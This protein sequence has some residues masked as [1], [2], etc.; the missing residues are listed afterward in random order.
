MPLSTFLNGRDPD[1]LRGLQFLALSDIAL[2]TRRAATS[3]SGGGASQ[4]WA[5]IG[6]AHCRVYPAGGAPGRVVGGALDENTTHF[7]RLPAG[8]D[9]ATPDRIVISGRGTFEV[10]MAQQ[11]T[12]ELSRLVEVMQTA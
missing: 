6:T 7:C 4:T 1:R 10:T 11:R 3:D 8:T 12:G 5:T 2:I 9:I